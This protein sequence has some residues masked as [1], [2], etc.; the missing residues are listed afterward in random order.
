MHP[1][2]LATFLSF[3]LRVLLEMSCDSAR[4]GA[5]LFE[6][7]GTIRVM[8]DGEVFKEWKLATLLAAFPPDG[9]PSTFERGTLADFKSWREETYAAREKAGLPVIRHENVQER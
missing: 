3:G 2:S 6:R 4:Y 1:K 8:V 9:P 5:I 7:V